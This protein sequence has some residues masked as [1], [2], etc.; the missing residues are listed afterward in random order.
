MTDITYPKLS[1]E[2]REH[3]STKCAA[4]HVHRNQMT[5]LNWAKAGTGPVKPIKIGKSYLWKVSDLRKLLGV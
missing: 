4:W 5:L 2:T 1:E 3:V